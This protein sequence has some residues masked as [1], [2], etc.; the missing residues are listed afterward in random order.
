MIK[1][2]K[3]FYNLYKYIFNRMFKNKNKNFLMN[4]WHKL[5]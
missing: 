1:D 5:N 2:N 4:L 3:L